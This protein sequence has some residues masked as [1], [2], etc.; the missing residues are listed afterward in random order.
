MQKK[1]EKILWKIVL[2]L[3]I[4]V[5][6]YFCFFMGFDLL[7]KDFT[8]SQGSLV[9]EFLKVLISFP[10]I[11]FIAI[12]LFKEE[13]R[14]RILNIKSTKVGNLEAQFEKQGKEVSEAQDQIEEETKQEGLDISDEQIQVPKEALE[15]IAKDLDSKDQNIKELLDLATFFEIRAQKFEFAFLRQYLVIN[16]QL[17]LLW[18]FKENRFQKEDFFNKYILP[19]K[20]SNEELEKEIIFKS[21]MDAQLIQKIDGDDFTISVKGVT[22]LQFL[23]LK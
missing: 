5:C 12:F 16:S 4:V 11:L 22:F 3:V 8:L 1:H 6:I 2:I 14:N 23:G 18:C 21:L 17:A 9:I 19:I 15:N 7:V 20:V 10:M 13:I